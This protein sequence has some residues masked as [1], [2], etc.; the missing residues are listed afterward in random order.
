VKE[1]MEIYVETDASMAISATLVTIRVL[2]KWVRGILACVVVISQ[3]GTHGATVV[4]GHTEK[5]GHAPVALQRV[6]GLID[7]HGV[8]LVPVF[9]TTIHLVYGCIKRS[10]RSWDK[11]V[12]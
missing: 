9:T 11:N 4:M 8:V 6:W 7:Q 12:L 10:V 1:L 2:A 3:Y 5:P